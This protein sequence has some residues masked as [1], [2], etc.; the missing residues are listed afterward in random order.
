MRLILHRYQLY[1]Y[2]TLPKVLSW[3]VGSSLDYTA[4]KDSDLQCSRCLKLIENL[5]ALSA[6][7]EMSCKWKFGSPHHIDK[8]EQDRLNVINKKKAE[9]YLP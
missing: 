3:L 9:L 2:V 7:W 1:I 5:G 8:D 6:H 4:S